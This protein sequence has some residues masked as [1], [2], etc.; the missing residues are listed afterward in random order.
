MQLRAPSQSRNP[1]IAQFLRDIPGY[2]ERI[3]MGIRLMMRETRLLGLPDPEF[4]EQHEFVVIFRNGQTVEAT[5]GPFNP[6]QVLGL[7]LIQQRGSITS[8]DYVEATGASESTALREL[9]EIVERGAIV[10]RGKTCGAR[11]F[12]S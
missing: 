5:N 11:Y 8:S 3:G 2:V 9:R 12:I 4:I 7:P 1:L 6:R 10:V